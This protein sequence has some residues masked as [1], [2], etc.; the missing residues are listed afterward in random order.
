[1]KE[2]DSE[3][4]AKYQDQAADLEKHWSGYKVTV[5]PVVLVDLG[6]IKG[7]KQNLTK[8][9]LLSKIETETIVT[10]KEDNEPFV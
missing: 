6:T 9:G 8:N 4:K 1:M 7:L 3:K 2:R 10:M 5:V